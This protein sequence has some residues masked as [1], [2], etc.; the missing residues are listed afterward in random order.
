MRIHR[1]NTLSLSMILLLSLKGTEICLVCSLKKKKLLKPPRSHPT[2]PL[3]G[4]LPQRREDE[5][6]LCTRP[7]HHFA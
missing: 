4:I 1:E 3:K 2:L 5:Y 6:G 7:V